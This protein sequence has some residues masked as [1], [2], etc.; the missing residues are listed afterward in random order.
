VLLMATST[1]ILPSLVTGGAVV[2]RDA[3]GVALNPVDVTNAYAPP[4]T[5][6]STCELTA[7]PTT[8]EARIEP[9]QINAIVSELIALA[10]CFDPD[11]PWNCASVQNLCT[12]FTWW[13]TNGQHINVQPPELAGDGSA[14]NPVRLVEVDGGEYF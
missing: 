12:A 5:F 9:G 14:A 2:Y 4:P 13:A 6:I 8:C 10:E 11:G 3:A 7:L 1:G